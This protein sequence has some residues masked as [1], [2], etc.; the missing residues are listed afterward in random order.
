[1]QRGKEKE[2]G[3]TLEQ[4]AEGVWFLIT[5]GMINKKDNNIS[6]PRGKDGLLVSRY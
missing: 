6:E 2:W 5:E 1:M 3:A 4:K